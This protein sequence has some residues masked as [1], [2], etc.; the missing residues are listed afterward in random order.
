[1]S[2]G[3]FDSGI[4]G[5]TVAREI[6]RFLPHEEIK[7][8]GDTARVPYGTKSS[9]TV[10]RYAQSNV[11]F[12]LS[13]GIDIL[14]IAC[15]TASAYSLEIL[16]NNVDIPVI[17]VIGPG[18]KKALETTSNRKIGIIGTPS[19]ISS[20]AYQKE[21]AKIDERIKV[22]TRSCPMFVPLAEEG[23]CEGDIAFSI[24][25]RYLENI[26]S[27]GI[28]TLILGC[29]HYPLLK[30]T[31]GSVLGNGIRLVDSAEE[32]A[33]EVVSV[34]KKSSL[35]TSSEDKGRKVFYLTDNSDTFINIASRFLGEEI[36][37]VQ[38]VDII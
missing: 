19:T 5:L 38:L 27:E 29:T 6:I 11:R 2:I 13:E 26:K 10:I 21:I 9:N 18:V 32:T 36:S 7:Y 31:I 33:K 30:K 17:G 1:M 15:N 20:M 22:Y 3:I 16:R 34:M 14:V 24:A 8:L 37:N 12:L 35:M 28:D 23:W 4:G 25:S